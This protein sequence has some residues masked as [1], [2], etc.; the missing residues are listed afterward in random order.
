MSRSDYVQWQFCTAESQRKLVVVAHRDTY[1][2]GGDRIPGDYVMLEPDRAGRVGFHKT[3]PLWAEVKVAMAKYCELIPD[4]KEIDPDAPPPETE[5]YGPRRS[6]EEALAEAKMKLAE[7]TDD[8]AGL[9]ESR[10]KQEAE[11]SAKMAVMEKRNAELEARLA[12]LEG[13]K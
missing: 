5:G 8:I 11:M 1:G 2:P 3:H 9:R 13:K 12:R 6:A 7:A 10:G 4:L